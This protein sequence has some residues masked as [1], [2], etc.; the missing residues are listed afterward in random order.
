[1]KQFDL[2]IL[3]QLEREVMM[4]DIII[5]EL[6]KQSQAIE[7]EDLMI[8]KLIQEKKASIQEKKARIQKKKVS[9]LKMLKANLTVEIIAEF[10][11]SPIEEIQQ[12]IEETKQKD[13]EN[14]D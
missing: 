14:K 2:N 3:A 8:Q 12:Y 13:N 7:Q 5:E 9:I 11:S 6:E 10:L 1:M 4:R